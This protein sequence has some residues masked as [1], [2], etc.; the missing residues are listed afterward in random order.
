MV[1]CIIRLVDHISLQS[2]ILGIL[3]VYKSGD[4]EY[5]VELVDTI[6]HKR[7]SRSSIFYFG[8]YDS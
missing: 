4:V 5:Y 8:F 7:R 3:I 6:T 1:G 2:W